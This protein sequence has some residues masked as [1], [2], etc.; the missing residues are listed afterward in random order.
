MPYLYSKYSRASIKDIT[1]CKCACNVCVSYQF[2]P[3]PK[4]KDWRMCKLESVEVS[5][6]IRVF[7]RKKD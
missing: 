1:T 2:L 7:V 4:N 6:V 5:F 3:W